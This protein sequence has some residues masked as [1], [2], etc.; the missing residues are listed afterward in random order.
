MILFLT[1]K[2]LRQIIKDELIKHD[3]RKVFTGAVMEVYGKKITF[4]AAASFPIT[5]KEK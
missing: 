2:K 4:G 3:I 1:E 5:T